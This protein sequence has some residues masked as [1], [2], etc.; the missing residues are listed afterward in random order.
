MF[1]HM[2]GVMQAYVKKTTPWK[3][4]LYFTVKLVHQ[5]LSKYYAEVNSMTGMHLLS[6]YIQSFP[7]VAILSKV[8]Q[9]NGY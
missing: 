5:K 7:L 6:A 1:D 4:N 8:G 3:D 2:D 9:R